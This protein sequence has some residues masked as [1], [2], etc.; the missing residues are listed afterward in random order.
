MVKR[1]IWLLYD[2]VATY[3]YLIT[4][5]ILVYCTISVGTYWILVYLYVYSLL[6]IMLF[7]MTY[8]FDYMYSC[9]ASIYTIIVTISTSSDVLC[10]DLWK[11]NKRIEGLKGLRIANSSFRKCTSD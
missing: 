1:K 7:Y 5:E 8:L 3:N 10:M 6:A 11:M 4:Q 2:E 9:T